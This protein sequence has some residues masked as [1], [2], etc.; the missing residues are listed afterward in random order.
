MAESSAQG[1]L[2]TPLQE[3]VGASA[4]F[5]QW[6]LK[7]SGPPIEKNY[8]FDQGRKQ[9]K[10]FAV[11]FVSRDSSQYCMGRFT[12]RGAKADAEKK[13]AE[14]QAKFNANTVWKVTHVQ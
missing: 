14:A 4:S 9:G 13:F 6:T 8:M 5:G 7:I 10:A 12:R 3:L 1:D 2:N 11:M